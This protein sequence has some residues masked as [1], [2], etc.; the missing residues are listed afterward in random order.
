MSEPVEEWFP[1]ARS[2]QTRMGTMVE[3]ARPRVKEIN[4]LQ[5]F[6]RPVDVEEL[7]REDHEVRAVWAFV[8]QLDLRGFYKDIRAVEGVAGREATDPRLLVSLWIY[9]Y[10]SGISSA[11]EVS[12]LC[13][14]EP[15]FQW[16]TGCQLVNYH[17]LAD[18]RVDHKEALDEL[19]K[20][21]LAVL[22]TEDLIT[23]ERVMHD[24]TKVKANASGKSFR[25]EERLRQHLK[26][27]EEQVE[28]M[29]DPRNSLELTPRV[30]A[31]RRR[32]A[33]EREE[34]LKSALTELEAIR[35]AKETKA[36]EARARASETDPE[37]RIMKNGDG[38]YGPG[39]NVQVSTDAKA[40]AI[41]GIEPVQSPAD[42]G[43]LSAAMDRVEENCG[44]E[45]KQA[46]VDGGYTDRST[47]VEMSARNIDLIG[48]IQSSEACVAN[49]MRASGI[50]E[51]FWPAAFR[52]DAS[53]NHMICPAGA[54]L[55]Y[56]GRKRRD[57][58]IE[59]KYRTTATGCGVCPFRPRCCPNGSKNGRMVIR[60]E[61]D[62]DVVVFRKKMESNEAKE[63][64]KQR[65]PLA[66][67]SN[68]WLKEKIGLRRFSM[69][70]RRKVRMETLW[71]ALTRNI[72]IWI[73]QRWR[74]GPI[75]ALA[76]A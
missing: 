74:H 66:E 11:R 45:A 51:A 10:K 29:G 70:G 12:R 46:V 31:A 73:A 76:A 30:K 35:G 18:F 39:Y 4:R 28:A 61:E 3:K 71:A 53:A 67:F 15:A 64:Y 63:I 32:A 52:Y 20:N 19:F 2:T 22:M 55:K 7:V 47:V 58:H 69:R 37:A 9:A 16:L 13:E 17:T 41:V 54:T 75:S 44:R 8:N 36:E 21:V 56:E 68:L 26:Q 6:L 34:K 40:G 60:R 57:G 65:A 48:S 24:G 14:Y 72:Q 38:G 43:Q 59:F 42:N 23:L 5:T 50:E 49:A 33:R 25:R 27:A 1:E 62:E